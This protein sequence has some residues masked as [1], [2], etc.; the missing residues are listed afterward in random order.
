MLHQLCNHFCKSSAFFFHNFIIKIEKCDIFRLY[1]RGLY[2]I[3]KDYR[4]SR[5]WDQWLAFEHSHK[6]WNLL[7]GVLVQSLIFPTNQLH[8]YYQRY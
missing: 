5:L 2:F 8:F 1:E 7:V 3:G 4:S 6:Q